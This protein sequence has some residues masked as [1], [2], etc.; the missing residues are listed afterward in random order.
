MDDSK[1]P[2]SHRE[3]SAEWLDAALR[4][5]GNLA[6]Q[7]VVSVDV[8]PLDPKYGRSSSLAVIRPGYSGDGPGP[9][10]LFAKFVSEIEGNRRFVQEFDLFR[11]EIDVYRLLAG[12][13]PVQMPRYYYGRYEQDNDTA[14]LLTEAVSGELTV[15]Q[16]PEARRKGLTPRTQRVALMPLAELHSQWWNSPR[17]DNMEWLRSWTA[18]NATRLVGSSNLSS[19][20]DLREAIKPFISHADLELFDE[21]PRQL[22]RIDQALSALPET[23]C[24]GDY[25]GGNMLW[26]S[27]PD[28]T[29]VTVVDWQ[30]TNRGPAV[31]D[32][33]Y[34]LGATSDKVR[35]F[36][37]I[38]EQVA[39]YHS[40]VSDDV[41]NGYPL[42]QMRLDLPPANL[43]HVVKFQVLLAELG[44][45]V[46]NAAEFMADI[47]SRLFNFSNAVGVR[48][49]LRD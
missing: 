28:A 34:F 43:E 41:K 26:D 46:P 27:L 38:H 37:V 14:I 6:E 3:M 39:F 33:V 1:I 2:G 49:W 47:F 22:S 44:F 20:G 31:R 16:A 10:A 29:T 21:A 4:S 35:P 42:S 48:E 19:Q 17:L 12:K 32:L 23:L 40:Q 7:R 30:I 45:A 36:D 5:T 13:L 18:T 25:H 15:D 24:H 8:E 11:Y 9:K